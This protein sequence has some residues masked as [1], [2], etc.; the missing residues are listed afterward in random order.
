MEAKLIL[1]KVEH[2]VINQNEYLP[3]SSTHP[4]GKVKLRLKLYS[5]RAI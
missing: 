2:A 1:R 4:S 5:L 3:C